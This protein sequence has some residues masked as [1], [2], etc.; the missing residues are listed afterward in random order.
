M[1]VEAVAARAGV[2]VDT[3]RYYQARGLL[4]APR[5]AGR[6]AWYD[7]SHVDRLRWIRSMQASGFS[8]ASIARVLDGSLDAADVALVGALSGRE[9]PGTRAGSPA[10]PRTSRLMSVSELADRTGIPVPVLQAVVAEGLLVPRRIGDASGYTDEDVAAAEA[11]LALLGWGIPLSDLLAL[12]SSHHRA[13]QE[14]AEQAVALFDTH[15]RHRLR[16]D[17]CTGGDEAALQLVD[18]YRT[19]LPAA[20]TLVSHHFTRVLLGCALDHIERAGARS[21]TDP[22]APGD[23]GRAPSAAPPHDADPLR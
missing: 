9:V 8:L 1:R 19:L 11:G 7:D 16:H 2:S 4:H 23:P 6:V 15:V 10:A 14:V 12:A 17:P 13:M 20:S 5:R 18:A 22:G 3:V 21:P